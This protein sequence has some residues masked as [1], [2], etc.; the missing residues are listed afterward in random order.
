MYGRRVNRK[1]ER[2]GGR[3]LIRKLST[4]KGISEKTPV[5]PG[6]RRRKND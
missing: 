2:K 1:N 5:R 6:E 3:M 4:G